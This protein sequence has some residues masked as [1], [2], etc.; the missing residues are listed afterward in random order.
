VKRPA[1]SALGA[2]ALALTIA[3]SSAAHTEPRPI[4]FSAIPEDR[5]NRSH[6]ANRGDTELFK[7][8][9][10]SGRV[11]RLT[12]NRDFDSFPSPS[13][14][15]RRLVFSARGRSETDQDLFV[16]TVAGGRRRITKGP[17]NDFY[18]RWSPTGRWIVFV[19]AYHRRQGT[20]SSADT[21]SIM[22]VR[23][24]GTGLR[25]LTPRRRVY[26]TLSA[27]WGPESRRILFTAD[28]RPQAS[29]N[30]F[31]MGR[32]GRNV[33]QI[34]DVP[35]AEYSLPDWSPGG[36]SIT[37][38]SYG[39]YEHT[40]LRIARDGSARARLSPRHLI[41][42]HFSAWGPRGRRIAFIGDRDGCQP[43]VYLMTRDGRRVNDLLR[44]L[45]L[46]VYSLDW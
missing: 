21:R 2:A 3:P 44:G 45:D 6:C 33:R 35:H 26:G 46:Q 7:V 22:L 39:A 9:P 38:S 20:S 19:R 11:R 12:T 28:S 29:T 41:D 36:R 32:R 14:G 10:R 43:H 30:V 1:A 27:S 23:A 8:D 37:V 15:G 34:T 16:R 5:P 4:F 40:V 25:R 31:V 17:A 13:P 24:D 42:P 18:P